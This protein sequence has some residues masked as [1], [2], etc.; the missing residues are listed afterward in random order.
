M[1][2]YSAGTAILD[3]IPVFE[4]VQK[5]I[6]REVR[7]MESALGKKAGEDFGKSFEEGAVK[8]VDKALGTSKASA[9]KHGKDAAE[10]YAGQFADRFKDAVTKM[11]REV[12]RLTE[13][14]YKLDVQFDDK[15]V[16]QRFNELRR[17]ITK[18]GSAKIGVDVQA[19]PAMIQLERIAKELKEFQDK[20]V[21][22]DIRT[23]LGAA[24]KQVEAFRAQV[25][26]D[27]KM[28]VDVDIQ[29]ERSLG[30]F[31][32]VV[33]ARLK[34][35]LENFPPIE[36]DADVSPAQ[37]KLMVLRQQMQEL[38]QKRIGVDIKADKAL[39]DMEAIRVALATMA[40]DEKINVDVR[41]DAAA[42]AGELLKV[43]TLAEI[44]DKTKVDIKVDTDAP[45]AERL[46][47]RLSDSL[48]GADHAG[49]E[50][51]NAL[52]SFNAR[53]LGIA[54]AVPAAV[55]AIM[56][57]AG[58]LALIG[59]LALGAGAGLA[60]MGIGFS[61]IGDA[62]GALGKV[63]ENGGR[64]AL[65][66][67][68]TMRSAA[69]GVADAERS[70]GRAR[71][72][73]GRASE[74]AARQVAQAVDQQREAEQGL[75][76]A[77]ADVLRAQE[78]VNRAREEARERLEDLQLSLRGGA[79]AE[80]EAILDL[81]D[82]QEEYDDAVASGVSGDARERLLIDLEQA[83]L[84]VDSLRESNADMAKEQAEFDRTGIEGSRE[85]VGARDQVA[86]AQEGVRRATEDVAQAARGVEDALRQ[87]RETQADSALAV[88]DAQ[89]SLTLAQQTY[90][91][92]LYDTSVVGSTSMEALEIA[93]GKLGPAGQEFA[94]F[95]YGLTPQFRELRNLVQAGMFPGLQ[96]AI[97]DILTVN[98]PLL[99]VFMTNM[100]ET[101]GNLF[102]QFGDM[103]TSPQWMGIWKTFNEYAPIFMQQFG[104]VALAML[105][106]FGELFQGL[107]PY[108]ER[109]GDALVRLAVA[110][111]DWIAA[112]TESQT[113]RDIMEWLFT[114]GPII[115][116]TL[117][118]IIRAVGNLF[119]A[120]APVG[121]IILGV[122]N[123]F[124]EWI[125]SMD[126]SVLGAAVT[127]VLGLVFAFQLA[128]GAVH[129]VAGLGSILTLGLSAWVFAVGAV[130]TALII[131][132][133]QSETFRDIMN[134]VFG[135]VGAVISWWWENITMPVLKAFWDL[136]V[137]IGDGIAWVWEN[138][139]RPT[140][141]ALATAA[142][143]MWENVL[144]PVFGFIAEAWSA[145]LTGMQWAWENILRPVWDV[146]MA[147][148]QVLFALLVVAI[149]YPLKEVW[150]EIMFGFQLAWEQWLKPTWEGIQAAGQD[151]MDFLAP[152]FKTLGELWSAFMT[153]MKWVY[154]EILYPL[155][156]AP[157]MD[158]LGD[159]SDF[160]GTVVKAISDVWDDLTAAL[161]VPVNMVIKYVLNEG[162]FAAFNNI[163]DTLGL[164][165]D[166]K[167]RPWSQVGPRENH[168]AA[169]GPVPGWSPHDKAD[170]IPAML[171]ANEYVQPVDT[172]R[173]YGMQ[174][175]DLIRKKRIP[176]EVFEYFANGGLVQHRAT[177]GQI[178]QLTRSVF[179]RAKLNSGYRPGD[180]GYHGRNMAADLGEQGFP[181]G[182][183]RP[184][185]AAMKRWWVDNYGARAAE[186]IY[187]GI[188]NDRS[189]ILNGR[190]HPYSSS[191][192]RAHFNHLHVA[193]AAALAGAVGGPMGATGG[194]TFEAEKPLWARLWS[195][196]TEV[197][198][199]IKNSVVE[200]LSNLTAK[201]GD[202]KLGGILTSMPG[203]A[204]GWMWD[205]IKDTVTGM[206]SSLLEDSR[207][208][209]TTMKTGQV[210]DVVRQ[211]AALRGW[212][213]GAEWNALYTLIQKE[214][215]WDPNAQN[216]SST[217]YGLFQ[218]L[219]GT[220]AGTGHRK[221]NDPRVQA[222]AGLN[223]IAGR[224]GTP[225][226]ALRFHR[227]NNWYSEG[228][229]VTAD[230]PAG[231][232]A[233][234]PTLYDTG[235]WLPPGITTV[236]NA[237]NKPEPILTAQQWEEL[238]RDRGDGGP[239]DGGINIT[240]PMMPTNATPAEVADA[241]LFAGRVLRRGGKYVGSGA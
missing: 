198:T 72:D 139:L 114:N 135:A 44:V 59:P 140:W 184:Y 86:A 224:Y 120:L 230:G 225:S 42:A 56:A 14:K 35:A 215:S 107:A 200:P 23:N 34:A 39:R 188:G 194:G 123:D 57:L 213:Q 132:Y 145:I 8:A 171:T 88:E 31:E 190:P 196:A 210:Q 229:E 48:L 77:Q 52:R 208:D 176:R 54:V 187:N 110:S 125:A 158:A 45:Q 175:M 191:T 236:L 43:R 60:V 27:A 126:P 62:V 137:A 128:A 61:G 199:K 146:I 170:N 239:G 71:A 103:M 80:R 102:S 21:N 217:A 218:F 69:E 67:S 82:A 1:A 96:E 219:N 117:W 169:G 112:F 3:V 165:G 134:A 228:G 47:R 143:W 66:A 162:L 37:T 18:L 177:G 26:R 183:G 216:P 157:F 15:Q 240:V 87:Q 50:T 154:D 142:T 105:T 178:Y 197:F 156:I 58:G 153:G 223:Y 195:S 38:L 20:S 49:Q 161:S 51:A 100:G 180:P 98:G 92:A 2:N 166:L 241:V 115:F 28:T 238:T 99:A 182:A 201:L 226:A 65:A 78:A 22:L 155:I 41:T 29:A 186:I 5:A 11:G 130:V 40:K 234:A 209:P 211:V 9:A 85:V 148:A 160:F 167:I 227:A 24:I 118:N 185:I 16:R 95:W 136:F 74:A 89:R 79:L 6:E 64:D 46:I 13:S 122:L 104:D 113:F 163:V 150:D 193:Y 212:N 124:A 109:F 83:K 90:S 17:E 189:N 221:S 33:K 232:K 32:K 94:R 12:G 231:G 7:Q 138:V 144:Q 36:F 84:R 91:D 168:L 149:F 55:P 25:Q 233:D 203:K 53:I 127:A 202:S 133:T 141:E 172:T 214:S 207:I 75:V 70:L 174:A 181:G 205:K 204:I 73:S 106:F 173:Y 206:F 108:S 30:L 63:Q 97:S 220:W 4:G 152:L 222:E 76:R 192:Q 119:E 68:R 151:L 159:L 179:P 121:M 129:L 93:M 101:L 237:T 19:G 131:L 10:E 81:K 235:G 111:A 116:E 147:V 164:S